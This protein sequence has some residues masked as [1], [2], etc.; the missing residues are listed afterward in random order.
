MDIRSLIESYAR[1]R[2]AQYFAPD[3]TLRD[4][5]RG[6]AF[7]GRQ[8]IEAQLRLLFLEA[9]SDVE[10]D[11]RTVAVDEPSGLAA[12]EWTFRGRHT[13]ELWGLPLT[14]RRV[15]VPMLAVY[16]VGDGLIRAGRLYYDTATVVR[17]LGEAPDTSDRPAAIVTART[18]GVMAPGIG[19][20]SRDEP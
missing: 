8:A 4:V 6:E 1:T 5:G 16:E 3:A 15:E 19:G 2:D 14:G 7:E 17:Q 20:P 12:I 10:L 11:V 18:G 9:F 13:G